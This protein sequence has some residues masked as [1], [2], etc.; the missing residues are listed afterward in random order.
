M[1]MIGIIPDSCIFSRNSPH[2]VRARLS[3]FL[4]NSFDRTTT[5]FHVRWC[6]IISV[7]DGAK[8]THI[9]VR[10]T[11]VHRL[12]GSVTYNLKVAYVISYVIVWRQNCVATIT[13]RT[14]IRCI[15][16]LFL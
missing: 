4:G 10:V 1:L 16:S 14:N 5:Y 8:Y 15:Y 13:G 3:Q 6:Q 7:A 11:Y 9:Y 2:F 12:E